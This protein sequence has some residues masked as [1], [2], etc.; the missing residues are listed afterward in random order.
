MNSPV[1]SCHADRASKVQLS[2]LTFCKC[3]RK[4]K[5]SVNACSNKTTDHDV[6]YRSEVTLAAYLNNCC[7]VS[8]SECSP[9]VMA[10][11]SKEFT[12]PLCAR[13]FSHK[14]S[15]SR[16]K[17]TCKGV[18]KKQAGVYKCPRCEKQFARKYNLERHAQLAHGNDLIYQCGL[19]PA[20]FPS[21][22][23]VEQHRRTRHRNRSKFVL[24][25][26]AHGKACQTYRLY[27][28]KR[29]TTNFSGCID[30]AMEKAELLI[31]HL[32]VEKRHMKVGLN[33]SLRF[34]KPEFNSG[35]GGDGS[36]EAG[37]GA[38]EREVITYNIRPTSRV[39]TFGDHE[40]NERRLADSFGEIGERF[41]DFN[42]RGSGWILVD[43]LYLDVDV[44]QCLSMQG[45][46]SIH[47]VR[48][49]N[50]R[51]WVAREDSSQPDGGDFGHRCFFH[52]VAS[53]LLTNRKKDA[54]VADNQQHT[55]LELETFVREHIHETVEAPVPLKRVKSFETANSHLDLAVNVIYGGED[56]FIYPAY[57]SSNL[58]AR[59]QVVLLLFHR[60]MAIEFGLSDEQK[61]AL[62]QDQLADYG[63]EASAH[64]ATPEGMQ[65][66]M[67]YA[68]V[69]DVSRMFARRVTNERFA[70]EASAT[71]THTRPRYHCYNCFNAFQSEAALLSHVSYCHSETGQV[72]E[73]PKPNA[74][75][76]FEPRR[77]SFKLGYMFF[78][79]FETLQ[80]RE[81]DRVWESKNSLIVAPLISLNRSSQTSRALALLRGSR[82]A[83]AST[84]PRSCPSR[85][86]SPTPCCASIEMASSSG[87][88]PTWGKTRLTTS[89]EA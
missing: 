46:C 61:Q 16:H 30:Y 80:V 88:S 68:P 53:V 45:S 64:L 83:S 11:S 17:K 49:Q 26:S 60:D 32:I 36:E 81:R 14:S 5:I 55:E 43:C 71:I 1:N 41:G 38:E 39:Y 89:C 12:C 76:A 4:K 82:R 6:W 35:G 15:L 66:V 37:F 52:A 33:L 79:D 48:S 78:F 9:V 22:A 74:V 7:A 24:L 27:L 23:E 20:F 2:Q 34:A 51:V 86:R 13:T 42:H 50:D 18:P 29:Y 69:Y 21:L 77:K 28:P 54:G 85:R 10:D 44:G 63:D 25:S 56:G 40:A 47:R 84:R 58:K 8:H 59:N 67:H 72:Y 65:A 57:A 31:R 19:C 62:H 70:H 87:T 3:S 73:V 75:V